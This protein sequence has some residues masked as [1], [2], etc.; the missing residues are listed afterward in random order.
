M[1]LF[2]PKTPLTIKQPLKKLDPPAPKPWLKLLNVVKLDNLIR[3][4]RLKNKHESH[5]VAFLPTLFITSPF[6]PPLPFS[7][8]PPLSLPFLFTRT[9]T[10]RYLFPDYYTRKCKAYC[11]KTLTL[12]KKN[13]FDIFRIT[14]QM[15]K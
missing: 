6:H 10:P 14:L 13:G 9:L 7:S 3:L 1:N 12:T 15:I 8:P 5:S 11:Y 4:N 2:I